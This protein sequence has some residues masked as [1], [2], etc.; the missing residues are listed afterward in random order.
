MNSADVAL[1]LKLIRA[2]ARKYK[3]ESALYDYLDL[4][5]VSCI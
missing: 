3:D 4:V 1:A 5:V 2:F